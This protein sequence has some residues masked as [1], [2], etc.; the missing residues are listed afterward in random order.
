MG[1]GKQQEENFMNKYKMLCAGAAMIAVL[2]AASF[3]AYAN[4]GGETI[5]ATPL[6]EAKVLTATKL[7]STE[8][9]KIVNLND[10]TMAELVSIVK[11]DELDGD[12]AVAITKL[13][14]SEVALSELVAA[15]EAIPASVI[16]E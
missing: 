8:L 3:P 11:F 4:N 7:D 9:V 5:K 14:G 13:D 16:V 2:G 6:V 15:I 12:N 10:S 1:V